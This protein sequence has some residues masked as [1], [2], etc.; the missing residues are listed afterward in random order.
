MNKI[1]ATLKGIKK[2]IKVK[3]PKPL[4]VKKATKLPTPKKI[5]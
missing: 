2:A 5:L 1:N 3:T 4:M